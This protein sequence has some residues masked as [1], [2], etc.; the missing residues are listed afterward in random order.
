MKTRGY[1]NSPDKR[2]D[3]MKLQDSGCISKKELDFTRFADRFNVGMRK[4]EKLKMNP[5]CPEQLVNLF[6]L[7]LS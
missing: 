1:C 7:P 2:Y 3:G 6:H 5:S 4:R